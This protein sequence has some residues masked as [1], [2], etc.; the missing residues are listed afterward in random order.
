MKADQ[1]R[2]LIQKDL[3]DR[4]LNW[5]VGVVGGVVIIHGLNR[6][7]DNNDTLA[8]IDFLSGKPN[9]NIFSTDLEIQKNINAIYEKYRNQ[10]E[11][12]IPG[13]DLWDKYPF[14][15][16]IAAIISFVTVLIIFLYFAINYNPY[17]K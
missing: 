3:S 14:A 8:T 2:L 10:V 12:D 6:S 17:L 13:F 5:Y 4:K 11:S 1:M 9:I 7:I 15:I 16:F